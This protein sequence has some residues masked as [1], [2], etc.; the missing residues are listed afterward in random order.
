MRHTAN[1]I[2]SIP[3]LRFQIIHCCTSLKCPSVRICQEK[4]VLETILQIK[5]E[6]NKAENKP[7]TKS[8]PLDTSTRPDGIYFVPFC[9]N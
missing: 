1:Q 2:A 4:S 7:E 8:K 5:S 6:G 9:D 3:V